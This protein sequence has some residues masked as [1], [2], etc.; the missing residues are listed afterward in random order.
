MM[1][2]LQGSGD[3]KTQAPLNGIVNLFAEDSKRLFV[4]DVRNVIFVE[5]GKHCRF[6]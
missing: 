4:A 2:L 1:P 6:P 5:Q 3:T